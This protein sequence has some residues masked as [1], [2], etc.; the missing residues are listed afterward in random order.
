MPLPVKV[1][2]T[3]GETAYFT[4]NHTFNNQGFVETIAFPV[5]SV[6]FNYE[7]QILEKNSTVMLDNT[8]SVSSVE[9]EDFALYPNPAKNEL[10]IKGID[11]AAGFSIHAAD[12]KLVKTGTYQPEK[13]IN[14]A[15]LEPGTYIFTI[16][17]KNIKFLKH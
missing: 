5:A 7:Y 9:K 16:K 17:E 15:D 1:T 3:G 11:R 4:L 2:G 12:G 8:L 14:I 6:Q 13:T 10:Y